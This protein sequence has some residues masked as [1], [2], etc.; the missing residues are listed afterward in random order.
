[1]T[2]E[3]YNERLKYYKAKIK[4]ATTEKEVDDISYEAFKEDDTSI[5]D[6]VVNN[7]RCLYNSV[8]KLC[9]EKK[10]LLEGYTLNEIK[11][12]QKEPMFDVSKLSAEDI[13]ALNAL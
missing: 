2:K 13:A 7:K 8:S 11:A 4:N 3:V 12:M 5:W 10:M 9:V 6:T 1:M